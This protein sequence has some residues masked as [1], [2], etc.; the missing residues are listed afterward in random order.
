MMPLWICFF[1]N[2][3]A[4]KKFSDMGAATKETPSEVAEASDVVITMLPASSHVSFIIHTILCKPWVRALSTVIQCHRRITLIF[5]LWFL[6]DLNIWEKLDSSLQFRGVQL[7][8]GL[9]N[10]TLIS[11]TLLFFSHAG[12]WCLYRTEWFTAWREFAT[13]VIHRFIHYW[14]TNIKKALYHCL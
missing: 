7:P 9:H 10:V 14:S 12:I 13:T 3:D 1:R 8:N 2:C 6:K 5:H 4:M 11:L